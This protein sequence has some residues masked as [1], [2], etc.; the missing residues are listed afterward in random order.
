MRTTYKYEEMLPAEFLAAVKEMPVFFVP[1]GLLEWH[2]D[3]LP[4]GQDALKAYGICLKAAERLGGGI[5][6]PP[7][8][9]G[10]PGYG[11]YAGT[12]TFSEACVASIFTELFDE[13]RKVGARVIYLLTGH[14]GPAQMD[15][16]KHI[17]K[18]YQTEHPELILFARAEYEGVKI[19]GDTPG[20]H[21]GKYE[22]SMFS[23]LYPHLTHLENFSMETTQKYCY[24]NP[25]N[26]YYKETEE[27][28]W[29]CDLRT[30]SSPELG[31]RCVDAI[32]EFMVSSIREAMSH[33]E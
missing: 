4:L 23:Y 1:T 5:V 10:R 3:H 17:A 8:Y 25:R 15:T 18:S 12:L 9:F 22:T 33:S 26:Y 13:L 20:D 7:C 32:T 28:R 29:P 6:M 11:A 24:E 27:W 19:D 16:I 21:A 14:Y 2:G 30:A 31:R